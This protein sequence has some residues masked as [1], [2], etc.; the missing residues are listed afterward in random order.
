MI[1]TIRR[2]REGA[3]WLV[4][5]LVVG[6]IVF[7]IVRVIINLTTTDF[8]VGQSF[9]LV[10]VGVM[11]LTSALM[12]LAAVAVCAFLD[13]P[14]PNSALITKSAA[15]LISVGTLLTL[16]FLVIGVTATAGG[17]IGV[18]VEMLGGLTDV[19]L[20]TLVAG[21]LWVLLRARRRESVGSPQAAN[22][23]SA[24][25]SAPAVTS[26]QPVVPPEAATGVVWKS[27]GDA[28]RG[29]PAAGKGTPGT[30]RQW[31]PVNTDRQPG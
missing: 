15:I 21:A 9:Q 20:K 11:G 27:A 16:V 8:T 24:Q 23:P 2:F 25:P 26:Q 29:N 14:S 17:A 5:A 18:A 6:Q 13:P 31:R 28:A 1:D 22:T 19:A 3:A 30:T 12:V 10:G 7:G 4:L